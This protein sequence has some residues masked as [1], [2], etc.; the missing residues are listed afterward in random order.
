MQLDKLDLIN[1][2]LAF[3]CW[4]HVDVSC[5]ADVSEEHTASMITA[6]VKSTY[7]MA[8]YLGSRMRDEQLRRVRTEDGFCTNVV[9]T[10]CS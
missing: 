4:Y 2:D 3:G 5:V 6:E 8:G 7:C 1:A 10:T 9:R